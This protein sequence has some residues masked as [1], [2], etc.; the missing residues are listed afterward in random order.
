MR[1][2]DNKSGRDRQIGLSAK[3]E[4]RLNQLQILKYLSERET[5]KIETQEGEAENLPR[6]WRFYQDVAPYP[7]Q[8]NCLKAW[9]AKGRKGIVKVVTGAGKTYVAMKAV[10]D[11]QQEDSKLHVSVIVPTKVL[12]NQWYEDF[13]T[14][15]NIP[16]NY[17]GRC[18]G[19]Y[20]QNFQ[21]GFRILIYVVNSARVLLPDHVRNANVG[22]HHFMI[23]DEC[24]RAGSA[25]NRAIFGAKR[26][27]IIGLSATPEREMDVPEEDDEESQKEQESLARTLGVLRE[28][29]GDVIYELTYRE[30][31]EQGIVPR[32]DIFHYA[33]DL[34]PVE[35]RKYE[36]LSREIKDLEDSLTSSDEFFRISGQRGVDN[37]FQI[38]RYLASR[39]RDPKTKRMAS[40]YDYLTN[41]RKRLLYRARNR[42]KCFE[43]ILK[44]ELEKDAQILVFHE[45]VDGINKLFSDFSGRGYQVTLDHSNLPDSYRE[46]SLEQYIQRN[47]KVMMSVKALIEGFNVPATDVGIIVASSSSPRQ[48]VQSIGR[49]LRNYP[50]KESS[51]I[52]NI[53]VKDSSDEYIFM[54][55]DWDR[56]LGANVS[57]YCHW[58]SAEKIIRLQGPP[59]RPL[60]KEDE[61]DSSA[62][63]EGDI[64]PGEYEGLEYSCDSQGNIFS[65]GRGGSKHFVS[66][67]QEVS[68][69]I[70]RI[71]GAA[72]TFK[73]TPRNRF[74]IVLKRIPS[75][76]WETRF[77]T[78]LKEPFRL[79]ESDEL[80][81]EFVISKRFGG[82]IVKTEGRT[83]FFDNATPDS[84]KVM[85][86][87]R[88]I[89]TQRNITINKIRVVDGRV[90]AKVRGE[91][92]EICTLTEGFGFSK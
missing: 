51:T 22:D 70:L 74:V 9:K 84:R 12:M 26:K 91:D 68:Q 29:I 27:Y 80:P 71:R 45:S 81:E 20:R 53:Y 82:S 56:I 48:K 41:E 47:A 11:I 49:V 67:P 42:A 36:E 85:E 46:N 2:K 76:N 83:R 5:K 6:S 14:N 55:T 88:R 40:R 78:E 10:E 4:L 50:G 28:E 33:V 58:Q 38:F 79:E 54:R 57:Q 8:D 3:E 86:E 66:N 13:R 75:G 30:A 23:V 19:D 24:H 21:E 7:W 43:W 44:K 64:Y 18:G 59:H 17:I 63:K 89:Q 15:S 1:S 62:L 72:G 39:G 90:L 77:V 25:E 34:P 16:I 60:P 31:L 69:K 32:F 37:K 65:H 73:V 52:Y 87:V 92:I 61:I 35:R